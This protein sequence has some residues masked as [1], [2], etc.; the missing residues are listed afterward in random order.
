[1]RADMEGGPRGLERPH[2]YDQQRL[3]SLIPRNPDGTPQRH[4]DPTQ[5]WTQVQN[6]GGHTVPGRGNNCAD[7][8]RSF[9]ESWYGNPQ[10]SAPRTLDALPDGNYDVTSP[11]RRSNENIQEWAGTDYRYDGDRDTG[12]ANIERELLDAGHGS[13]SVIVVSWPNGGGH[14]FNA[15]NHNGRVV[16]VDSQTGQVSTNPIHPQAVGVWH[17]TLDADRNPVDPNTN[18]QNNQQN[19]NTQNPSGPTP[20]TTDN[21]PQPPRQDDSPTNREPS[22][23]ASLASQDQQSRPEGADR[24]SA[25]GRENSSVTPDRQD[26]NTPDRDTGRKRG[27][28]PAD[29]AAQEGRSSEPKG[30]DR[31]S[32]SRDADSRTPESGRDDGRPDLATPATDNDQSH[33]DQS[34]RNDHVD[35]Q[36]GG[37]NPRDRE[38]SDEHSSD[39]RSD[40]ESIA[41]QDESQRSESDPHPPEAGNQPHDTQPHD[42][43][44][45]GDERLGLPPDAGQDRLRELENAPVRPID[46]HQNVDDR[47]REWASDGSLANVLHAAAGQHGEGSDQ[48]RRLTA[49]QLENA[50]PGFSQLDR[51]ERMVAVS[52]IARISHTFHQE[53]GVSSNPVK[54]EGKSYGGELH[55]KRGEKE[56]DSLTR[57][58]D[59][60]SD[61]LKDHMPDLT[62]RN[63]A[64][65]EV[66]GPNG[67]EYV[68]D[69]S[70]PTPEAGVR[71]KHSEKALLDWIEKVNK[72]GEGQY[73]LT[74]LYT[75][76]EPCGNKK[77][78][79]GKSN[80]SDLLA[81]K[82][83][84][85]GVEVP[86]YFS[87]TYRRDAEAVQERDALRR[88]LQ[89]EA[90]QETGVKRLEPEQKREINRQVYEQVP[91]TQAELEMER[92]MQ[93][94]VDLVREV[95]SIVA[96]SL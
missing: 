65:I 86:V 39:R 70:Y 19:N 48:P 93:A 57:D 59:P 94:R 15:V 1:M 2:P 67:R 4:P 47:L 34:P 20:D 29:S 23:D 16:W 91:L 96:P 72:E 33:S 80:C 42:G 6:D 30:T 69:S 22:S 37:D 9:L 21:T 85:L 17:L 75:E 24:E 26:S 56:Y 68:V 73:D 7:C 89:R 50:L 36:Q 3:E 14:A 74:A 46:D 38:S 11:E 53:Y 82:I 51:G 49:S 41:R 63:Y 71:G 87:T 18:T 32:D 31:L 79:A 54:M 35:Y 13:A 44:R 83:R 60:V 45:P 5:P 64:V 62:Q 28:Q 52:A 88:Q 55:Q 25:T 8:S 12:Y 77:G 90:R 81:K 66:E 78:G 95:W 76:R 92:Q 61:A 84:Q 27:D 10:V 40:S 58:I 43:E